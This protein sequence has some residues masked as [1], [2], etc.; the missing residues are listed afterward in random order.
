MAVTYG[1]YDSV[2]GDR[3]YNA[4]EFSRLFDGIIVDGVFHSV[5]DV[6]K[7]KPGTGLQVIV[8]TGRAWFD[9]TW[10][11]NDADL[12][13]SL[14][15]PDVLG[16]IDAV[17][18]EVNRD[19]LQRKNEIKIIKGTPSTSPVKPALANTDTLSQHALAYV[20][21]KN[22]ISSITEADIENVVGR[23]QTPFVT[24]PLTTVDVEHLFSKW[25]GEFDAWFEHIQTELSGD[26]AGNLQVQIDNLKDTK[27]DKKDVGVIIVDGNRY[28]PV[29]DK[30][31]ILSDDLPSKKIA[32][33]HIIFTKDYECHISET[34]QLFINKEGVGKRLD[35]NLRSEFFSSLSRS[36][37]IYIMPNRAFDNII[38]L[39]VYEGFE[40]EAYINADNL[41]Y[42]SFENTNYD[43]SPVASYPLGVYNNTFY[44]ICSYRSGNGTKR[45]IK[46]NTDTMTKTNEDFIPQIGS[47]FYDNFTL[48]STGCWIG[49]KNSK[50]VL[51]VYSAKYDRAYTNEIFDSVVYGSV[52]YIDED[53]DEIYYITSTTRSFE[54]S[55]T[56]KLYKIN[57]TNGSATLVT[58]TI[59][60]TTGTTFHTYIGH[61]DANKILVN[62]G[63]YNNQVALWNIDTGTIEKISTTTGLLEYLTR[64]K[65]YLTGG[66][67]S[68]PNDYIRQYSPTI[69]QNGFFDLD[70]FKHQPIYIENSDDPSSP[71]S[72]AYAASDPGNYGVYISKSSSNENNSIVLYPNRASEI[73]SYPSDTKLKGTTIGYYKQV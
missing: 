37:P 38:P 34:E 15:S 41:K 14:E 24:G 59:P 60:F 2:G 28:T 62:Y 26:V 45:V 6:F 25:E 66:I 32:N 57:Y 35:L 44:T 18:I 10:T 4:E 8:G 67:Y 48:G 36:N 23:D 12:P 1:F 50:T 5:G 7:V 58:S 72:Y 27:A 68:I 13:I 49:E 53:L 55:A 43:G 33:S 65:R 22:G 17:V 42:I 71:S 29:A 3:K 69:S 19:V 21:V 63:S 11:Y 61:L 16:R 39:Y 64:A 56:S 47:Q 30:N 40:Q 20:T 9:G 73:V 52:L 51:C 31:F 46:I 70:T 54:Y